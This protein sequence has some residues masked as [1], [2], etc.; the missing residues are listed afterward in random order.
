MEAENGLLEAAHRPNVQ[1]LRVGGLEPVGVCNPGVLVDPKH[2]LVLFRRHR[3]RQP[4]RRVGLAWKRR[5][6]RMWVRAAHQD[7]QLFRAAVAR[8]PR[9]SG[10]AAAA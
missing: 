3:D 1:S 5:W 10:G 2:N 9:P 7:G 8:R 4:S 6:I